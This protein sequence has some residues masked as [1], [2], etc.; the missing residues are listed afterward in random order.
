[1]SNVANKPP[2]EESDM[3]VVFTDLYSLIRR[4]RNALGAWSL[5][6][7]LPK[8]ASYHAL[9]SKAKDLQRQLEEWAALVYLAELEGLIAD[10]VDKDAEENLKKYRE[11]LSKLP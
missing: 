1:M 9:V 10:I 4:L 2:L 8:A 11:F 7:T 3:R 6:Y 5:A